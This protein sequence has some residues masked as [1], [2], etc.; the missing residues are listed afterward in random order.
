[1]ELNNYCYYKIDLP[2]EEIANLKINDGEKIENICD[3]EIDDNI[4]NSQFPNVLVYCHYDD[5]KF[6]RSS[7]EDPESDDDTNDFDNIY[8]TVRIL[9]TSNSKMCCGL[10]KNIPD[11]IEYIIVDGK[12]FINSKSKFDFISIE[13]EYDR[14]QIIKE[15]I[16]E[17]KIN[18][19]NIFG[20]T[21]LIIICKLYKLSFQDISDLAL[22]LINIMSIDTINKR[23]RYNYTALH[24]SSIQ[25]KPEVSLKLIDKINDDIINENGA[26]I[27]RHCLLEKMKCVRL[28]LIDR[29]ND[30][31]INTYQNEKGNTLLMSVIKIVGCQS[32]IEKIIDKTC[33][34]QINKCNYDG[35]T[36]LSFICMWPEY[37]RME[38]T[39]LKLID[40][41]SDDKINKFD[42]YDKTALW[43]VCKNCFSTIALKLIQRMS[44]EAI[45]KQSKSDLRYDSKYART[46]PLDMAMFNNMH[47]VV[48]ILVKKNA[49]YLCF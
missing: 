44:L 26:E 6:S 31:V 4:C 23:D 29:I 17:N 8:G 43:Y 13:D 34:E 28:K 22:N 20:E 32:S 3:I 19:T 47:D 12:I 45:N 27:L 18:E 46:T 30:Y 2:I 24:Y 37:G 33:D 39:I 14:I 5:N 21:I 25:G 42:Q 40:K 49:E 36:A 1:M 35:D 7:W 38:N 16:N 48:K 10:W 11:F 15:L 41:M 9:I